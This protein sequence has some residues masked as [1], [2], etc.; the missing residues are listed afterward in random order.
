MVTDEPLFEPPVTPAPSVC[1]WCGERAVGEFEVEPAM[2]G[3]DVKT[4][5]AGRTVVARVV[6]KHAITAAVCRTHRDRFAAE[7]AAKE[8]QKRAV[9]AARTRARKG[10]R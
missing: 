10:E 9:A 2:H 5:A 1:A 6:R 4:D 7:V 3:S 8:A